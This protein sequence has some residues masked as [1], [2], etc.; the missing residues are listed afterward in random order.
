MSRRLLFAA[1]LLAIFACASVTNAADAQQFHKG[2][3]VRIVV[4]FAAGG[5]F[6][7]YARAIGRHLGKHIPGNPAVI[8]ENMGGAGSLLAANDLY[9]RAKPDGLT[10]GNFIGSLVQQQL[11]E[12]K[13]VEFDARKFEWLGVPVH[14]PFAR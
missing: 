5:G 7:T 1:A 11:F 9:N 3:T 6:D 4:G 13:G 2:K 12:T 8:V 14:R 10:I